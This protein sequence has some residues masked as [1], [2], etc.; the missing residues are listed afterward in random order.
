MVIVVNAKL[1][2]CQEKKRACWRKESF[3]K[4]ISL[5]PFFI[6]IRTPYIPSWDIVI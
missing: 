5:T 6:T 3:Q 1:M 4:I 2:G